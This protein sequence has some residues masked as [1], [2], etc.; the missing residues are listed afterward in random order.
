MQLRGGAD[1]GCSLCLCTYVCGCVCGSVAGCVTVHEL[2]SVRDSAGRA[3]VAAMQLLPATVS[4]SAT[5][6]FTLFRD[7][8]RGLPPPTWV[9]VQTLRERGE[10]E[11]TA[12]LAL[13]LA[14]S[15]FISCLVGDSCCPLGRVA[16]ADFG[17]A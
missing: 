12:P 9:A 5:A 14:M 1:K 15:L 3:F 11:D 6:L 10:E 7:K 8:A 4:A 16:Y 2:A 17:S 13:G